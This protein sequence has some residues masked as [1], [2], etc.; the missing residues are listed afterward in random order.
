VL[1]LVGA[2]CPRLGDSSDPAPT[3]S[4][5]HKGT[6]EECCTDIYNTCL[7]HNCQ[8]WCKYSLAKHTSSKS[9]K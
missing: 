6:H 2:V 3:R 9:L 5:R 4:C 1:V 7:Q 8:L